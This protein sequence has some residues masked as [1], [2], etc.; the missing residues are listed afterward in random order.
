MSNVYGKNKLI[1][2]MKLDKSFF[3]TI[4]VFPWDIKSIEKDKSAV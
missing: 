1:E 4:I 3:E 2:E